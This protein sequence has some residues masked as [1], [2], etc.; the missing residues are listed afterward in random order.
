MAVVTDLLKPGNPALLPIVLETASPFQ[1]LSDLHLE[2]HPSYNHYQLKQAAPNLALLGDIDHVADDDL[3]LF[4]ERQLHWYWNVFFLLGNHEPVSTTWPA[5]QARVRSF[6]DRMDRLRTKSTIGRFV[7]LDGQTRR[8]DVNEHLTIL[9]CTLFSNVMPD[10][11]VEVGRRMVNFSQIQNWTVQ[12]HVAAH[13][14]DLKWLNEQVDEI[15]RR[16]PQRRIAIFT[17][18][19]PTID[20]RAVDP[21]FRD[22]SPVTSGFATDLSGE[23][24]WRNKAVVLWGFGHT[25]F[26]CDFEDQLTGKRVATNQKG[27]YNVVVSKEKEKGFDMRKVVFVGE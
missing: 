12:D 21:R 23:E 7:F 14:S 19:S 15:A 4:L 11:A 10:E 20:P 5:A 1:I 27:Y 25:H 26:S 8:H 6:S 18:H 22:G 17:H 16:E 3:F 24:C 2:T 13:L 9:G